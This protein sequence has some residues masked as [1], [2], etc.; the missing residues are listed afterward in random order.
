MSCPHYFFSPNPNL[1]MSTKRVISKLIALLAD[2]LV[3]A[4]WTVEPNFRQ[5]LRIGKTSLYKKALR[6][7]NQFKRVYRRSRGG[8]ARKQQARAL[9]VWRK[10]VLEYLPTLWTVAQAAAQIHCPTFTSVIAIHSVMATLPESSGFLPAEQRLLLRLLR[11]RKGVIIARGSLGTLSLV[12]DAKGTNH[13]NF[14]F[15]HQRLLPE[16]SGRVLSSSIHRLGLQLGSVSA[17]GRNTET[18]THHH[19]YRIDRPLAL[20]E[21]SPEKSRE[22]LERAI[23]QVAKSILSKML[24]A[25]IYLEIFKTLSIAEDR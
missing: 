12:A 2:L 14:V 1:P 20:P 9:A 11:G 6:G 7:V 10:A 19:Q 25:F 13:P 3:N 17:A 22:I 8:E 5:F 24:V 4:D 21:R 18:I 23:D 15:R 16:C